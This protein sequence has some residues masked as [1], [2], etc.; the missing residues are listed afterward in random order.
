[1]H[2]S[3]ESA[4]TGDSCSARQRTRSL[5]LVPTSPDD[6]PRLSSYDPELPSQSLTGGAGEIVDPE[7][8]SPTS[9]LT[10]AAK[11]GD[12]DR[13]MELLRQGVN[14]D[15]EDPGGWT[16]LHWAANRDEAGVTELLVSGG[17]ADFEKL[18]RKGR[19]ALITAAMSGS[20]NVLQLLL[21]K[22]A[23]WDREDYG[24]KTALDWANGTGESAQLLQDWEAEYGHLRKGGTSDGMRQRRPG[25]D[26]GKPVSIANTTTQHQ[27]RPQGRAQRQSQQTDSR[28]DSR[29]RSA[30]C[31]LIAAALFT[32]LLCIDRVMGGR[33]GAANDSGFQSIK[34]DDTT[35]LSAPAAPSLL[36]ASCMQSMAEHT[37]VGAAAS[38]DAM[39]LQLW[40]CLRGAEQQAEA[41]LAKRLGH[42]G[43]TW[44]AWR[45]W[46]P[47]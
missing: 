11:V 35:S 46:I 32:V 44:S 19:T 26:Q 30:G 29:P 27:Q 17:Q 1:M 39:A 40:R 43:G 41:E 20:A 3:S 38:K 25:D 47:V 22:G 42:S 34:V 13:V 16:A 28:T 18:D 7:H 12:I 2:A 5:H 33:I 4:L 36:Q 10:R 6:R 9:D 24:G 23:R 15:G 21:E 31:L 37:N 8:A 14:V 45:R